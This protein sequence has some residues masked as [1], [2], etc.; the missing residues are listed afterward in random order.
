MADSPVNPPPPVSSSGD[1]AG[2]TGQQGTPAT[3]TSPVSA[4]ATSGAPVSTGSSTLSS[5]QVSSALTG[6]SAGSSRLSAVTNAP[7]AASSA[8]QVSVG[9]AP[10]TQQPVTVTGLPTSMTLSADTLQ[11][12]STL[13]RQLQMVPS[14]GNPR[15]DSSFLRPASPP[16]TQTA[17]TSPTVTTT[18][19]PATMRDLHR[20]STF[21]GTADGLS[22]VVSLPRLSDTELRR[23]S[24]LAGGDATAEVLQ[25]GSRRPV[26]PTDFRI[27][28]A[29]ERE[30]LTLAQIYG[31]DGLALRA[32]NT[33][34]YLQVTVQR[35]LV[36]E[37]GSPAQNDS[38]QVTQLR[39]ECAQLVARL[40]YQ[41]AEYETNVAAL[42]AAHAEAMLNT[43]TPTPTS[44]ANLTPPGKLQ[45]EIDALRTAAG[46]LSCDKSDLQDQLLASAQEVSRLQA[47]RDLRDKRIAELETELAGVKRFSATA[48][49]DF[50]SGNAILSGHW[51]RL[52]ELMQLYQEGRA[53]PPQFRT[54][55]QVSARDE[56]SD[57]C[58]PYVAQE[59]K[60]TTLRLP[61]ASGVSAKS[62]S[63]RTPLTPPSDQPKSAAAGKA[64][65]KVPRLSLSGTPSLK[66]VKASHR[67]ASPGSGSGDQAIDLTHSAASTPGSSRVMLYVDRLKLAQRP[68]K[69]KPD[70]ARTLKS[71]PSRVSEDKAM[72]AVPR[73]FLWDD[74]RADVRE[75][76]LNGV[77]FWDAVAEARKNQMLHDQFG[78][79]ALTEML[80]SAIY[81][82]AL[83][84]TPWTSFVP[85]RY[86]ETAL[87]EVLDPALD[88]IP[89]NWDPLP[90]DPRPRSPSSHG[91]SPFQLS[92]S[93]EEEDDPKADKTFRSKAAARSGSVHTRGQPS[94]SSGKRPRGSSTSNG[95]TK[96]SKISAQTSAGQAARAK[97]NIPEPAEDDGVIERPRRGSWFHYRPL[98][99]S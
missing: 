71:S 69:F 3:P 61:S 31:T 38:A 1:G 88:R 75:L 74:V 68:Q 72:S 76:M 17:S 4:S 64:S 57:D 93:D 2:D 43:P 60:A 35:V 25:P 92:S 85:D 49:M 82:E 8:A 26:D 37:R 32:M 40:A 55:L 65:R 94:I 44:A 22:R 81:W 78:K 97:S 80:I 12:A 14:I 36:L 58:G 19:V 99:V 18:M 13:A 9:V 70:K 30:A 5:S 20:G 89:E 67:S 45:D 42:E 96:T 56:D 63:S 79:F 98:K 7:P 52:L 21:D 54:R 46:R 90:I 24:S 48:L 66:G 77:Q 86:F 16:V 62:G 41:K 50:L 6:A 15:Q 83:D 33:V 51:K 53:V 73:Q 28:I 59:S 87:K 47:S 27:R 23:L 91:G 10:T 84:R 11:A 95:T 39:A 29:M 34:R